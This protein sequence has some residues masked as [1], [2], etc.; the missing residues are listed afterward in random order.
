MDVSVVIATYN[1]KNLLEKSL[2]SLFRQNYP[3]DK[4]EIVIVDDGSTDGTEE[5]VKRKRPPCK[6]RYFRHSERKGPSKARNLGINK[7]E[8]E[9]IIFIDSDVLTP[10]EFIREH[11]RLHKKHRDI[12][13]DGPAINTG[14]IEG[15]FDNRWGK[16]LASLDFFG[17][18]F[19]TANTSCR[20][21][22][23][24][25]AGL[26]DEEFGKGYGW[27]DR[28]LGLK[29]REMGVKRIKNRRAY[30]FHI[31]RG[32]ALANFSELFEKAKDRGVNAALYYKKHPSRKV[33]HE[34]RFRYLFYD[35]LIF[36][37]S[38]MEKILKKKLS[39]PS[40]KSSPLLNLMA[41]LYLVH[42]YAEGLR[43]GLKKFGVHDK[44]RKR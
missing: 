16:L 20:K 33:K 38:W 4:Y 6:L 22:N 25:K 26:F 8:G 24:L 11:M 18:S 2:E 30:A 23:L 7:A 43:E 27:F 34:I 36:F 13:V 17:A 44:E 37:K 42:I 19:I 35:R 21:E 31:K 32:K 14:K 9:V 39:L 40:N 15:V 10:P 1:R 12:I 3:P 29:L 5:M 41:S 28:E